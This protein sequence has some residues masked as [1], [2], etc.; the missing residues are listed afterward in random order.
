MERNAKFDP[1]GRYRYWLGRC[2]DQ[3]L[4]AVG[5]VMLNPSTADA[6]V[7]DPTIRRCL[8]FAQQ[9][10]FGSLVVT[11]LF[12][13]RATRPVD[14]WAASDPVGEKT[15][16]HLVQM[17]QQVDQIVVAWGNH[18]GRGDRAQQVSHLLNPT[19]TRVLYCLGLTRCQ[20]PRH[21]LYL[22]QTTRLVP[23]SI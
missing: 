12:A 17:A 18:G 6:T 19:G 1:S 9:W 5:F 21:P 8:G 2:W 4:P 14:L 10:G 23:W 22:P 13:Y 20:Q 11:N 7:N 3:A 16:R 15:D